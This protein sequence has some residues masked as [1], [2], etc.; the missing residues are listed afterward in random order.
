MRAARARRTQI[1]ISFF[2]YQPHRH[3][4][5]YSYLFAHG[6]HAFAQTFYFF[7]AQFFARRNNRKPQRPRFRVLFS[8]AQQRV[9]TH[10]RITFHAS[11]VMRGLRA[12][13][14]V[15]AAL[16]AFAVHNGTQV[17]SVA[18]ITASNFVGGFAQLFER[19]EHKR[20]RFLHSNR[21]AEQNFVFQLR[22]AHKFTPLLRL[23]STGIS[24]FATIADKKQRNISP[25]TASTKQ[26]KNNAFIPM[27]V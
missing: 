24:R 27:P 23:Q 26:Y 9:G 7:G 11:G 15:F 19:R 25:G 1:R 8:R 13:F 12:K 14:A 6:S 22:N 17:E 4:N 18:A 20:F 5:R 2:A 10:K 21:F 16:S 3:A